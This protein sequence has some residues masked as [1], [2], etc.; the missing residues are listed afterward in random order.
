[1]TAP[2]YDLRLIPWTGGNEG[3]VLR[4]YK[5][6]TGT[7]TIGYGFTWGSKVF[8]EWWLA[9]YGRKMRPGDTITK[10][11]ALF[12]LGKLMEEDYAP[13]VIS[14]LKSSVAPVTPHA[15]AA[16]VD[17]AYNCG[18]GSLKWSWFKLLLAGKVREAAARYEVTARTSKGRRS[19]RPGP[20]PQG[21]RGDPPVQPLARVGGHAEVHVDLA[22]RKGHAVLGG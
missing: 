5:D 16:S 19:A 12:L 4:W 11:D 14:R 20:A 13:P 10:S 8:R 7:G 9:K 18:A 15:A 1:M 6:P 17:M 22:C 21:R 2:L 3:L